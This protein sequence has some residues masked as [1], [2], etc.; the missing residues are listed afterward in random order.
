VAKKT[1]S[2]V[3]KTRIVKEFNLAFAYPNLKQGDGWQVILDANNG[4]VV[5]SL[6][7]WADQIEESAKGLR[8]LADF[9]KDKNGLKG[10]GMTHGALITGIKDSDLDAAVEASNGI[11]CV[12]EIEAEDE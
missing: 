3:A 8:S 5:S 11:A 12:D 10:Q 9:L 6:Q 2:A 7:K 1:K 4:D